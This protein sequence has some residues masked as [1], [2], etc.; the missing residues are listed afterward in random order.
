MKN[1]WKYGLRWPINELKSGCT[2]CDRI[3]LKNAKFCEKI[4][5]Q[6]A[7]NEEGIK[8]RFVAINVE[9]H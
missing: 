1:E 8:S 3:L 2:K 6:L 9:R 7:R 4:T 5:L